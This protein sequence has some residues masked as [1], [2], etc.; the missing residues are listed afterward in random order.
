MIKILSTCYLKE[1]SSFRVQTHSLGYKFRGKIQKTVKHI[2]Y[3]E[4]MVIAPLGNAYFIVRRHRC[5]YP[6][7]IQPNGI[8][9]TL[10]CVQKSANRKN[11]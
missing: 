2:I 10:N 1:Y 3:G 4:I 7:I 5:I 11:I 8:N 9:S 6:I